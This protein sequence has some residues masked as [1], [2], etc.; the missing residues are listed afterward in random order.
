LQAQEGRV[1]ELQLFSFEPSPAE[2]EHFCTSRFG[3][4]LDAVEHENEYTGDDI[5]SRIIS[6]PKRAMEACSLEES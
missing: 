4:M 5:S 6:V 2:R 1:D 3:V